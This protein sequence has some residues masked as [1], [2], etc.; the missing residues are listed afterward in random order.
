MTLGGD[1]GVGIVNLYIIPTPRAIATARG[2]VLCTRRAVAVCVSTSW[3]LRARHTM[4]GAPMG[5]GAWR[6]DG[7]AT[8]GLRPRVSHDAPTGLGL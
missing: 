5:G 2:K 8:L 7:G 4:D 6:P 3:N 1:F